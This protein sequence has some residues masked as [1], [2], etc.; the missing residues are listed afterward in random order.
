MAMLSVMG[1]SG[2]AGLGSSRAGAGPGAGLSWDFVQ[3]AHG[4][5]GEG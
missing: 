1:E 2:E 5:P 4:G 3:K